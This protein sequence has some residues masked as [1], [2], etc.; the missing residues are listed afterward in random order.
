MHHH[1]SPIARWSEAEEVTK[2]H[3]SF[4]LMTLGSSMVGI[5][6]PIFLLNLGYKVIEV[7]YFYLAFQSLA[8]FADLASGFLTARF[9]PKHV[10]RLSFL[11]RIMVLVTLFVLP[12]YEAVFYALPILLAAQGMHSIAYFTEFSKLAEEKVSNNEGKQMGRAYVVSRIASAIGPLAGGL[13]ITNFSI[14]VNLVIAIITVIAAGVVLNGHEVTKTHLKTKVRK[15]DLRPIKPDLWGFVGISF[16]FVAGG[17]FY[18][19]FLSEFVLSES[20]EYSFLGLISTISFGFAIVASVIFGKMADSGHS[21][22]I[23]KIAA[24][25][26]F[27]VDG[28]R[29]FAL[30][31]FTTG[32]VNAPGASVGV[33]Q[34]IPFFK[35]VYSS[36]NQLEGYRISYWIACMTVI[37]IMRSLFWVIFII[38]YHFMELKLAMQSMFIIAAFFGLLMLKAKKLYE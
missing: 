18:G 20:T 19:M 23:V 5:F 27:L 8:W 29:A 16:G 38:L 12:D 11:F 10:M 3:L 34:R 24:A 21:W 37:D 17:V 31:P 33:G 2:L 36:V 7:A 26:A 15:L 30:T 32:A 28:L 1:I 14:R 9:G 22:L 13:I 25:G 6:I 4:M 35:G